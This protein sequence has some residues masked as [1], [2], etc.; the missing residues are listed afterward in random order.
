MNKVISK[1]IYR[2]ILKYCNKEKGL[3]KYSLSYVCKQWF[4][5]QRKQFLEEYIV[6]SY[7]QLKNLLQLLE[8]NEQEQIKNSPTTS[9]VYQLKQICDSEKQ[10]N[11][12]TKFSIVK[13]VRTFKFMD[14]DKE[15]ENGQESQNEYLW[16]I[17]SIQKKF[18]GYQHLKGLYFDKSDQLYISMVPHSKF[19]FNFYIKS[20]NK[21]SFPLQTL[22]DTVK[23]SPN[24][25]SITLANFCYCSNSIDFLKAIKES[26]IAHFHLKI[27]SNSNL[28]IDRLLDKEFRCI[29]V[30]GAKLYLGRFNQL[31]S[32]SKSIESLN[33]PIYFHANETYENLNGL[34]D[35]IQN[36]QT[37]KS[38]K[39]SGSKRFNLSVEFSKLFSRVFYYNSSITFLSIGKLPILSDDFFV[40]LLHNQTL[41][42]LE[43]TNG[44]LNQDHL[45]SLCLVLSKASINPK[46]RSAIKYLSLKNNNLSDINS[47]LSLMLSKNKTLRGIDLSGNNFTIHQAACIFESLEGNDQLYKMDFSGCFKFPTK[48]SLIPLKNYLTTSKNLLSINLYNC[49]FIETSSST[50]NTT[51]ANIENT[52]DIEKQSIINNNQDVIVF[53][54]KFHYRPHFI[55]TVLR[56]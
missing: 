52:I 12:L 19:L 51:I 30:T 44:C 50:N 20:S 40:S 2:E 34:C 48:E 22:A 45:H 7:S 41:L 29:K 15:L 32:S 54:P 46:E 14:L 31:I 11:H 9:N 33:T 28:L 17:D 18:M 3:W 5:I 42:H 38:L 49:S 27:E 35:H 6:T 39:I 47:S 4:E 24:L 43:L 25:K 13:Q 23:R 1:N 8:W 16:I 21:D 10:S 37:M 36:N 26:S 53:Q 56:Q 55:P